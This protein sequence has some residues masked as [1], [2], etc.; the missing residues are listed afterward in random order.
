M[1]SLDD[2]LLPIGP[3]TVQGAEALDDCVISDGDIRPA[4]ALHTLA[5]L[6]RS[7][8]LS[9]F[10]SRAA[11]VLVPSIFLAQRAARA[12]SAAMQTTTPLARRRRTPTRQDLNIAVSGNLSHWE[13]VTGY[14]RIAAAL[15][16]FF[17]KLFPTTWSNSDARRPLA[18]SEAHFWQLPPEQLDKKAKAA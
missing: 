16:A 12:R 2:K 18:E 4:L 8:A 6:E 9:L 3:V 7:A 14:R 13:T 10:N 11:P 5:F 1:T 15:P 17:V